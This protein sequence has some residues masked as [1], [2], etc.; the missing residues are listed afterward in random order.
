M[1]LR[2]RLPRHLGIDKEFEG[3]LLLPLGLGVA[4]LDLAIGPV[5]GLSRVRFGT[6]YRTACILVGIGTNTLGVASKGLGCVQRLATSLLGFL[7]LLGL[8][9]RRR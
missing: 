4:K 8:L 3:P 2:G 5:E 1:L 9:R 6:S 7:G